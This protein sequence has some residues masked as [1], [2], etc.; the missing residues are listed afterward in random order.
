M[1]ELNVCIGSACHIHGSHNVVATFQHLIEK[2]GLHDKVML[3]GDFCMKECSAAGVAVRFAGKTQRITPEEARTF[4]K[5]Q[6]L[7]L[8][9]KE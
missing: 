8:A 4:F 1:I 7:P 6:I 5:E 3:K 2:Y 9:E